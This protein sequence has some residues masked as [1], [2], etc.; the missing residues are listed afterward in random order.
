M[1][2]SVFTAIVLVLLATRLGWAQQLPDSLVSSV[3]FYVEE[4]LFLVTGNNQDRHYTGGVGI[5]LS[6][7]IAAPFT[8][9]LS[10]LDALSGMRLR[11]RSGIDAGSSI[12]VFG[13]GFTPDSLNTPDPLPQDR[14]YASLVGLSA[15]TTSL[16]MRRTS[17]WTSELTVALLGTH[18]VHNAQAAVHRLTR[19]WNGKA[20]PYDPEGWSNQISEGGELTAMYAVQY[21][22][23]LS[24]EPTGAPHRYDASAGLSAAVGYYTN[25]GGHVTTRLGIIRTPFYQFRSNPMGQANQAG[26]GWL[27]RKPI[28]LFVFGTLRPRFVLYNALLQGQFRDSR[29]TVPS[30]S[31][32]NVV[33]EFETGVSAGV[34]TPG[35]GA[36]L[37]WVVLAGRTPE[38]AGPNERTHTWSSVFLTIQ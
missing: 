35:F 20:T 7:R 14:P 28:D 22:R 4:D 18:V 27:E 8:R 25:V 33:T 24:Q 10:V 13:T 34:M 36:K 30:S 38:F 31:V 2:R 1:R 6:G 29:V 37:T 21:E 12:T 15:R 26:L 23:L 9:P 16:D 5:Q 17:A 3:S 19:K 11:H 32:R